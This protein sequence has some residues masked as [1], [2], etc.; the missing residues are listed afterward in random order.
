MPKTKQQKTDTVET[1]VGLLKGAPTI[2]LTNYQ[3]LSV[4]QATELRDLFREQGVQYKVFKNSVVQLRCGLL[5]G[6]TQSLVLERLLQPGPFVLEKGSA[7]RCFGLEQVGYVTRQRFCQ[8]GN[9][10]QLGFDM[11]VFELGQVGTRL[12]RTGTQVT[13]SQP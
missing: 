5:L 4:G 13:K 12:V 9:R 1:I 11:A 3:G 10:V 7:V 6:Q 2:Y 8:G